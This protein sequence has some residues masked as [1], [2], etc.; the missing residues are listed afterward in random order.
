MIQP[1]ATDHAEE[2]IVAAVRLRVAPAAIA[3]AFRDASDKVWRFLHQHEGLRQQGHNV[4]IYRHDSLGD[5]KMQIDFGV[6]VS[7]RFADDGDV[8]CVT[9]PAGP[10]ATTLHRGPYHRLHETHASI[11][12]WCREN[13]HEVAGIDWEIYGDWNEDPAR[14]ETQVCH[15]LR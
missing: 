15:L 13:G 2:R 5:G 6:Q 9:T 7:R 11:R 12:R 1:I 14:L 4:F 10:V 3:I 8:L